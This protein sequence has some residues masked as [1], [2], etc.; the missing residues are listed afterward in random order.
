MYTGCG[1][2]CTI[3]SLDPFMMEAIKQFQEWDIDIHYVRDVE[4]LESP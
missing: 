4:A 2:S 1:A 3:S